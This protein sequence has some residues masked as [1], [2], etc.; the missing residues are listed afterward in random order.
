ML[1]S[2]VRRL[3]VLPPTSN[4]SLHQRAT[5]H[6]LRCHE[7]RLTAQIHRHEGGANLP[8]YGDKHLLS[9]HGPSSRIGGKNFQ[10]STIGQ[11]QFTRLWNLHR[12]GCCVEHGT[13]RTRNDCGC[14]WYGCCWSFRDWRL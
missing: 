4:Q 13:S 5:I 1:S 6:G 10:V 11:S 7:G 8:F 9:I 3:H 2:M 14:V 12:L